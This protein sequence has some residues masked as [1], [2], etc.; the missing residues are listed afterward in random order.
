MR[1]IRNHCMD[2]HMLRVPLSLWNC[3]TGR[4]E[5]GHLTAGVKDLSVNF[6][7]TLQ[8]CRDCTRREIGDVIVAVGDWSDQYTNPIRFD[9]ELIEQSACANGL[10]YIA[11]RITAVSKSYR[12]W[13]IDN[14]GPITV[15]G[16]AN[17]TPDDWTQ[18]KHLFDTGTIPTPWFAGDTIMP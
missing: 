10:R 18:V 2:P 15:H 11:Y 8:L 4:D 3:S 6:Q 1:E 7:G 5:A 12:F 13:I 14:I 9:M 16:V 17:Y